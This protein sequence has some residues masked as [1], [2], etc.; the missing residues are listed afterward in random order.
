MPAVKY[1]M[2]F[3]F[4]TNVNFPNSKIH[5]TAGWSESWYQ[6]GNDVA[7][8]IAIANGTALAGAA[9]FSILNTR[10][11]LLPQGAA[12]VGFR[13]QQVDPSGSA[14]SGAL[15][16]P[17][18]KA[19]PPD[20]PQMAA[21]CK[22]TSVGRAN[23]R[24]F[25]LR[26]IPDQY[27]TEGESNFV[28]DYK[29]LLLKFFLALGAWSFRARDLS[30]ANIRVVTIAA[31]GTVQAEAAIPYAVGDFVRVLRTI[32]SAG[33]RVGGRFMV[34]SVGPGVGVFKVGGWT[35]GACTLGSVRKDAIVYPQVSPGGP[36]FFDRIVT[37]RVGR[38]FVA[39][40]GRQPKRRR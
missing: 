28:G 13:V 39:Y 3:Q 23:I 35:A 11:A 7:G 15:T 10:A 34:T 12:I 6:P 33:Q 29:G 32:N 19:A 40:R 31:D 18:D 17:G 27:V 14:Q 25:T 8:T 2:L 4:A 26:G 24:R 9:A 1:T 21:L 20:I 16:L 37:R 5:R 22:A 38:P 36:D 30:Q